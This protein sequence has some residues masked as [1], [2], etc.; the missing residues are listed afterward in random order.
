LPQGKPA[1]PQ[2]GV[3]DAS[4]FAS[5]MLGLGG[6]LGLFG[7]RRR[8]KRGEDTPKQEGDNA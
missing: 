8:K 2:T 7:I 5:L 3:N 6:F 4:P 1:L